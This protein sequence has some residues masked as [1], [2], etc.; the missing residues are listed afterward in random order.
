M[1]K[2]TKT[3]A[4]KKQNKQEIN[5]GVQTASKLTFYHLRIMFAAHCFILNNILIIV[6]DVCTHVQFLSELCLN[7]L[8]RNSLRFSSTV[9]RIS[10]R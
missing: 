5:T 9:S 10:K 6:V 4:E 7:N 3:Q 1:K 8:A 2:T